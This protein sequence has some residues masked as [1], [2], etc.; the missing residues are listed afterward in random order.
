M[1][2]AKEPAFSVCCTICVQVFLN[3][4]CTNTVAACTVWLLNGAV[5]TTEGNTVFSAAR[6]KVNG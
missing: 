3:K 1:G 5:S 4:L 2:M 6:K